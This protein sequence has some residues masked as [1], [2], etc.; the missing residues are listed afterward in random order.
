MKKRLSL[1]VLLSLS[2]I[3]FFSSCMNQ[4]PDYVHNVKFIKRSGY[5]SSGVLI[6][7]PFDN[8]DEY[9]IYRKE[10]NDDTRVKKIGTTKNCIYGLGSEES[11]YIYYSYAVQAIVN[12][13]ATFCSKFVQVNEDEYYE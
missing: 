4:I 9:V 13:E 2:F 5:S 1:F 8:A 6:W 3:L 12:G 10:N 11:V 7:E